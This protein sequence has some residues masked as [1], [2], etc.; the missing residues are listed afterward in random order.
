MDEVLSF[1]SFLLAGGVPVR[2][3]AVLSSPPRTRLPPGPRFRRP[4]LLR[5]PNMLDGPN[6]M[7]CV[8]VRPVLSRRRSSLPTLLD[9]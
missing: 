1:S 3:L 5:D 8:C 9:V 6:D 2:L 4:L 7:G